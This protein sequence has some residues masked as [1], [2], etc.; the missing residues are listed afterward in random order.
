MSLKFLSPLALTAVATAL[1]ACQPSAEEPV[2][3]ETAPVME[4]QPE[5]DPTTNDAVAD[6]QPGEAPAPTTNETPPS[7]TPDSDP[8]QRTVQ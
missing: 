3:A 7:A 5:M 2:P 4:P 8:Q 1:T 6:V